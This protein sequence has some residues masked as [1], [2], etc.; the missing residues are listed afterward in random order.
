MT[1]CSKTPPTLLRRLLA[2]V[3][4]AAICL[5]VP[6]TA[7]AQAPSNK[8]KEVTNAQMLGIGATNILDTYLSPEKYK[9]L[10]LRYLSHTLRTRPDKYWARRIVH[11]GNVATANDRNDKGNLMGGVYTL[12]LAWLRRFDLM[13]GRL[14]LRVGAMADFNI[15]ALYNSRNQNNPAQMRLSM[16]IGPTASA[17]YP[18][19]LFGRQMRASYELSAPL[20]G[21]MFS[22]NYGQSYYE[23]FSL[24]NYDHN[25]VFT[26][27]FSAPSLR[28]MLTLDAQ[29]LGTTLRIGYLGDI[30]Q[31]EVNQLKQHYYTHA[32]LIGFV[33][34]L[35]ISY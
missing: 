8:D 3:V 35:K 17:E 10:E 26:T 2:I 13:D 34:Q 1:T 9:G 12:D 27:P 21:L 28:H 7:K 5:A 30:Q 20:L 18:F 29:V 14:L 33:K 24:G 32:L 6:P 22:P 15:G 16:Q 31:A 11:Q 4:V 19:R 23:I 25:A